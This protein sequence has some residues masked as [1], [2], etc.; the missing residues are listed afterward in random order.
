MIRFSTQIVFAF[1]LTLA[2]GQLEAQTFPGQG[3]LLVPPGAP[4]ATVG[5]TTSD[6]TV[7][8]I[9]ILGT[10]CTQIENV[11]IDFQHTFVG[12]VAIFLI[13]PT[14]EVLEL[15]SANG[16]GGDNYIVT[17]FSDLAPIF[18]TGGGP[19]YNGTFRPEGRQQSTTPPFPN[20]AP[21]GT[22]TFANTFDGVNA[23]GD[24]TLLINDFVAIDVGVLNSWS[25]TFSSGGGPEPDVSLG[26]D[27]T[28]CPGQSTTLLA[29]V[30]PSADSYL[31]NTG[32]TSQ[33]ISVSPVVNTTYMVTVTNNGC[34]DADTVNVVINPNAVVANAGPDVNIC[35]GNSTD[36]HATGGGASATFAWSNGQM[37][38][39]IT[40]SPVGSQ[41]YTVT[42]TDGSCT[43]TDQVVVN[44]TATPV[45]N[46][47]N[48]IM[49]CESEFTSL[50]GSGGTNNNQY[51]W[52][53]GQTG[54]TIFVNPVLTTTYTLTLNVNGC[55][56]DDQVTV[57]VVL[58]PNVFAG[59]DQEICLGESADLSASG[60][61]GTYEWSDGQ[62]GT[63]ITVTPIV[64]TLYTITVTDN[65]CEGTD[66]VFVEVIEVFA[67]AGPDQAICEGES[68]PLTATGGNGFL[69]STG[70]TN[71]TITVS[72]NV[73]TTYSVT[74]S[75]GI[76]DDVVDVTIDVNP[77]PV[78]VVS[79][80]L[81]ICE[82]QAA[83]LT[84]SGGTTF[85]WSNGQSGPQISV[86][87]V[88]PTTYIVT[89]S[90]NGCGSTATV[91]VDVNPTPVVDAGSNQSICE[92]ES[93]TLLAEISGTG[94][95]LWSTGETND[96]ITVSPLNTTNYSVTVTDVLGCSA[97]DAVLVNVNPFPV[98]SAGPDESICEGDVLNLIATGGT[99]P[100]SYSWSTGQSGASIQVSPDNDEIYSVTITVGGCASSDDVN[101]TLLPAVF[102][103]AGSDETVCEGNS[104]TTLIAT[105]GGEYLWS[106]G[107]TFSS[108]NVMPAG[109]TI[110][111]VTVT[112]SDGCSDVDNVSVI[113]TPAPGADAGPDEAI[114]EGEE[115]IL[116]ATGG[117]QYSWSNSETT[118]SIIVSPEFTTIYSVTVTSA[119]GCTDID[120]V[121]V[122]VN[123]LPVA[124][125]GS[126]VFI[127]P[128]DN[129]AL[130]ASGGGSYLW[131]TGETTSTITVTPDTTTTYSV[132]VTQNGCTA[133][134]EVVVFV[135]E[136]PAV[137]LGPDV[138][139]CEGESVIL[140]A[141]ISG[142]FDIGYRWSSGDTTASIEV[143]PPV[144][145][146]YS[147]TVSD[148]ASG[149]TTIDTILVEVL[150]LPLG[151]VII[152][153][154][155]T[156]CE[157][158]IISYSA[159]PVLNAETYTW[160][161]P[162]GATI[163][164]GQGSTGIDV[165]W[166][167]LLSGNV[168]L[169]VSNS[170]GALPASNQ[171]ILV[172]TVP[173]MNGNI[174]GELAP[175]DGF[176]TAYD[177][178]NTSGAE[179]F[180]WTLTG[181]ALITGG[182]G[183]QAIT[184]DWNNT[185]GGD[186]C[187]TASN[188][189][190]ISVPVCT[191]INTIMTPVAQAGAD[192]A[193]C[194][195]TATLQASG[196]GTWN[197]LSGP[198]STAFSDNADPTAVLSV[199]AT[200]LYTLSWTV[201]NG[202][203]ADSD[204]I[205]V[206]FFESPS[207]NSIVED[208]NDLN[209]G[210]SISFDII[211]GNGP[212]LVNGIPVSGNT[213]TSLEIPAATPYSFTV[214]DANG[215]TT[216]DVSGLNECSCVTSAGLMDQNLLRG[217]IDASITAQYLGGAVPDVNDTLMYVLHNGNF[218][219]GIIQW[220]STPTFQFI[221]GMTT[222][223]TYFISVVVGNASGN[224][225]PDINDPCI[226]VADGTPAIFHDLPIVDTGSDQEIGCD[227]ALVILNGT[228]STPSS[229]YEWSVF[230]GGNISGANNTSEIDAIT[231]GG[232]I[233]TVM[234]P[235]AGCTSS[236]SVIIT[237]HELSLN[238]L[239]ITEGDPSC[240][241]DCNGSFE[242]V[243]EPSWL[244]S[245]DGVTFI[246]VTLWENFC[247]GEYAIF[248]Q[249]DRGCIRDSVLRL[250]EPFQISVDLG[251]NR[252][253]TIGERIEIQAD[254]D[255][256]VSDIHWLPADC[257]GCP[258]ISVQPDETT[259]YTVEITDTHG[260]IATDEITIT[261]IPSLNIFVPT[262]FSPN[263]DNINDRL[264]ILTNPA[265]VRILNFE[266]FD[267][268]GNLVFG[269]RDPDPGSAQSAWDGT[270]K[271]TPLNPGVFV[272]HLTALLSNNLTVQQKGDVTLVR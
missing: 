82:G 224:G 263:G 121:T 198:G 209:T 62:T 256:I 211:G 245:I 23:D 203:C 138:L 65:G 33:S 247:S 246:P 251:Q 10:G 100:S 154:D 217:C 213:F 192:I 93:A 133:I 129:T 242:L 230:N 254:I 205:V 199:D 191:T 108:I 193:L 231:P 267:R 36:L 103:D 84:A 220:S 169:V 257:S 77:V 188:V 126:N 146:L 163:I 76:C 194:G 122:V 265:H 5:I 131:S 116:I 261:V 118:S 149:F 4:G 141:S 174:T 185:S 165:D 164:T 69:W 50:T 156:F 268:W 18:I 179:S 25:I 232:Y 27:I 98:A 94:F 101:V 102:A 45:A 167:S 148:M 2:L 128:G 243:G 41:T 157:G 161:V 173:V 53:T 40:V 151:D 139:I 236:D 207:V 19:P 21:L 181:G 186:L 3:G 206:E 34:I 67:D 68:I 162:T 262:V 180:Q 152:S 99:I 56:D 229:I 166:G 235:L 110:Y 272:Y 120:A 52:S 117:T 219:N 28:I 252:S 239:Q 204:D 31:W 22:F 215:C 150:H 153:G 85:S 107:Q 104:V 197:L 212:Y 49:I 225:L 172:E 66:A 59:A 227:P 233:L 71:A 216:A 115:S 64:S 35:S 202:G 8:G 89:V 58:S 55:I 88:V 178:T 51:T 1:I 105:G 145:T 79:P 201:D 143:M 270:Y 12:D 16:G 249:D 123:S 189:C 83:I 155:L 221:S 90:E 160:S 130:N 258:S 240:P 70:Q 86:T 196:A 222:G 248:I 182:Q 175:C 223:Q 269:V 113:V 208:C 29:N 14:G 170:C 20:A 264:L 158:S 46:A 26:A 271:G 9:G 37:G 74:V 78:A 171:D 111:S 266:V 250:D 238:G 7:T 237:Q 39:D 137:D 57:T 24:W 241:G 60:S 91:E 218:P 176:N 210:Y 127:L 72:P 177:I 42:V 226:A 234:D 255:G 6:A 140:D 159:L 54:P 81:T 124:D 132:T 106:T 195:L 134:D 97:V 135:N 44:V 73:T 112:N 92:G 95:F 187:V 136:L 32:A 114:C 125:A 168:V 147:V 96:E 30:I 15:S 253:I 43:G 11:T 184:I 47:G 119:V 214:T 63:D 228:S 144:T 142:P 87:P 200:G 244:Y 259:T 13:A 38:P 260:C 48:D 190:G 80:D 61:S 17:V 183:T 109:T 75:Q